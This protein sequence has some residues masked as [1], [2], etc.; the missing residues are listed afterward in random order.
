[1]HL[2]LTELLHRGLVVDVGL[3]YQDFVVLAE[4]STGE[5]RVVD[6]ARTLGLEK[7]RL[8]HQLRRL[9]DRGLVAKRAT[10]D[11]GRGAVAAITA[12]GRRL[13]ERALPGHRERVH[14][15]FGE[16]LTR[17]EASAVRAVTAKVRGSLPG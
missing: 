8:S 11:D 2:R 16:H 3:T 15:L 6:L 9:G 14:L 7:S 5:R 17:S 4:L 13:H 10:P 12:A 1:M